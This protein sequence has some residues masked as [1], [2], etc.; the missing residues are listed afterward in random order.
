MFLLSFLFVQDFHVVVSNFMEKKKVFIS[1]MK[2]DD[3]LFW[4]LFFK[5]KAI[6]LDIIFPSTIIACGY[7]V[8]P[9]DYHVVLLARKSEE[10]LLFFLYK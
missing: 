8:F 10:G 5:E 1:R 3:L 6:V 2:V 7:V 9:F 4:L